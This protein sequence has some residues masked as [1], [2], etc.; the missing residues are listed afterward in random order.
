SIPAGRRPSSAARSRQP[1]RQ[2]GIVGTFDVEN[3]GDLLFPLIARAM[4]ERRLGPVDLVAFSPNARSAP[5]WPYDV[6]STLDLPDVLPSLATR[7]LEAGG[8]PAIV[9]GLGPPPGPFIPSATPR[10]LR[11]SDAKRS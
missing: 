6:R 8:V 7:A 11:L 5:V 10:H 9:L 2:V 3:Y 4:L 1:S